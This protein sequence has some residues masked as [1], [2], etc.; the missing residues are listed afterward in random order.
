MLRVLFWN[1][2]RKDLRHLLGRL[3][4]ETESDLVVLLENGNTSFETLATLTSSDPNF[5]LPSSFSP[6]RFQVFCRLPHLQAEEIH[7]ANRIS[8]WR[9]GNSKTETVFAFVHGPDKRNYDDDA[10]TAWAIEVRREIEWVNEKWSNRKTVVLGDFNMNPFERGMDLA[11]GFN[12]VS[13]QKCAM[14]RSRKQFGKNYDHFY[15]P[16]WSCFGDLSDGPPGTFFDRSAQGNFGW[17][18]LDQVLISSTVLDRFL[19]VRI[20]DRVGST[21]LFRKNGTP[22]SKIASQHFPILLS[23]KE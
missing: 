19:D 12:A 20:I 13:T 14:G 22:N 10:R 1:V 8:F 16:M 23:L 7:G 21:L 15:N 3:A 17:S 4:S 6:L 5:Y 11:S 18:I 9:I 2:N